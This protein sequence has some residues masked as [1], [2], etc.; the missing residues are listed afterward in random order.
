MR[1]FTKTFVAVWILSASSMIAPTGA[2]AADSLVNIPAIA[3]AAGYFQEPLVAARPPSA[4]EAKA[5]ASLIS[6]Y[7]ASHESRRPALLADYLRRY[8]RSPWAPS[9]RVEQG[10]AYA[11]Q[12]RITQAIGAWE[13]VWRDRADR[14]NA[15]FQPVIDRAL[16]ELLNS[17]SRLG[18]AE[19]V[20]KLLDESGDRPV[21]AFMT[22]TL[23]QAREALWQMRNRPAEAFRCGPAALAAVVSKTQTADAS[24]TLSLLFAPAGPKG[25]SLD[26][27]DQLARQAG[28][29][30]RAAFRTS[31]DD[32][33]TPAVAHLKQGH[34]AALIAREGR[35]YRIQD[36]V[37]GG[38]RW[39]ESEVLN[40]ETSGYFLIPEPGVRTGWRQVGASE[41][42]GVLGAGYTSNTDRNSTSPD[43]SKDCD[44]GCGGGG[45]SKGMPHYS[46]HSLLV[47]LHI[48]DMPLGYQPPKGGAVEIQFSYNQREASQPAVFN[49]YN[50][51]P[52]W[53]LNWLSYIQ[54]NPASPGSQVTRAVAGGGLRTYSGYDAATGVFSPETRDGSQLVRVSSS[55]YER[56]LSDGSKEIYGQPDGSA[57]Y[58]RNVFL[59]QRVD[60]AGNAVSLQ[61][62]AQLRLTAIV[63]PLGQRTT[64]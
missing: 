18:H 24:Q 46:V 44:P 61:Y 43:D 1:G 56:R 47:S 15:A 63:A 57:V 36:P 23:T 8:P 60:R 32:I 27:L 6:A 35:R 28:L 52:K 53:T 38:E 17:H 5:L 9:L 49:A 50:L 45:S 33:P 21:P 42:G 14:A 19:Q 2:V 26:A 7:R 34:Y 55:V 54:D 22:E 59:T 13:A 40:E 41:A 4:A 16:A 48:E 62:D 25:T 11:Q 30:H 29:P 39:V 64:F 3:D 51:G 10:L 12:G 20:A 58:P 31:A 37:F